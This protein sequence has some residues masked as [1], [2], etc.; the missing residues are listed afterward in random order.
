MSFAGNPAPNC[1]ST[2]R[3]RNAGGGDIIQTPK[4]FEK[5]KWAK[6][7]NGLGR[8]AIC[9]PLQAFCLW[10]QNFCLSA[11]L[12]TSPHDLS[13]VFP[14]SFI[15]K[16]AFLLSSHIPLVPPGKKRP[17]PPSDDMAC[18]HAHRISRNLLPPLS[19]LVQTLT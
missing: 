6:G 18:L 5:T 15:Q 3:R 12:L 16:Y 8:G 4:V 11:W 2:G 7:A 10:D 17:Q 1:E 9:S 19:V 13:L 14:K